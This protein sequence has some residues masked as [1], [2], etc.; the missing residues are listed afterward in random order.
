MQLG[1]KKRQKQAQYLSSN[2][3]LSRD[4]R[5]LERGGRGLFVILSYWRIGII[6]RGLC[7]LLLV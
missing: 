4:S 6:F 5:L 3:R 7:V 1:L 2:W